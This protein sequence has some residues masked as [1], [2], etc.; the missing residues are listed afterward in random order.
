M[1]GSSSNLLKSKLKAEVDSW[2]PFVEA[3]RFEDRQLL[4]GLISDAWKYA[5]AVENSKEGCTT[6]AFLIALLLSRQKEIDRLESEITKL[7]QQQ[8]TDGKD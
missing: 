2:R 7:K 5:D 8:Q 6:E 1:D 3:L 4:R